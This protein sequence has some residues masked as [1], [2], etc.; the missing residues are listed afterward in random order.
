LV[1]RILK[2]IFFLFAIPGDFI[3]LALRKFG[4]PKWER[5]PDFAGAEIGSAPQKFD[6]LET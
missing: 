1:A 3:K 4:I 2:K 6:A 5:F